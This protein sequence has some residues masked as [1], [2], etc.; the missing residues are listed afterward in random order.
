MGTVFRRGRQ[1]IKQTRGGTFFLQSGGLSCRLFNMDPSCLSST[2]SAPMIDS[3]FEIVD[4]QYKD[5]M[6]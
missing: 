5:T 3:A 2:E 4:E 1:N 6:E